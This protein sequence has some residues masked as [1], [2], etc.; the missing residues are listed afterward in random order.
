LNDQLIV[1]SSGME[2][3]SLGISDGVPGWTLLFDHPITQA[4]A[5]F[6]DRLYLFTNGDPHLFAV[7][8]RTGKSLGELN[9]GDWIAQGPLVAG[10]DLVLVGKDGAVF[11]YR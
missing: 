8:F 6:K 5:F 2:L 9:T 1:A 4:P 3:A 11:L 7:D 10:S